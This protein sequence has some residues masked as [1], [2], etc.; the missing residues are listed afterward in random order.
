M[1]WHTWAIPLASAALDFFG[2]ERRNAAAA[3]EAD[4]QMAFQER[5][6]STAHQRQ[7]ADLRAAGLNPI[8]SA[9]YGGAS[10][11]GG[12]MA[13][14]QNPAAT[15]VATAMQ[16]RRM[17]A[18]V[19]RMAAETARTEQDEKV[20]AQE[21]RNRKLQSRLIDM[22]TSE[23]ASRIVQNQSNTAKNDFEM[24]RLMA[25][26][27]RLRGSTANIDV[28][29]KALTEQLKGLRQEGEIDET[30]YGKIMRYVGRLLPFLNTSATGRR[31]FGRK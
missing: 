2:G 22:Q 19:D 28:Q 5:M 18:E 17:T 24:E 3:A 6:S 13:Q 11:P 8:L 7:V 16:G 1:A 25:E 30:T 9:R 15:A 4:A 14:F 29:T 26:T 20:L 27:N 10:S 21:E 12:A 23:S 31:A